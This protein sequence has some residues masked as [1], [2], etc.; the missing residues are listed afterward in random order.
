M[1]AGDLVK[2]CY[3]EE[4]FNS[5]MRQTKESIGIIV[6][7]GQTP[8]ILDSETGQVHEALFITE[9]IHEDR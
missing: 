2:Y 6:I 9:V 3:I 1:K 4:V 8:T 7:P 5:T